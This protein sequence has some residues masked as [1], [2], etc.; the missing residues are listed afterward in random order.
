[1]YSLEHLQVANARRWHLQNRERQAAQRLKIA[2]LHANAQVK[3]F[4]RHV[5]QGPDVLDVPCLRQAESFQ[6]QASQRLQIAQF[7]AAIAAAIQL[8]QW[9]PPQRL[10]VRNL[11]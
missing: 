7:H 8:G 2:Q 9:H 4:Q 10:K 11:V 1:A 3:L 6:F 5:A